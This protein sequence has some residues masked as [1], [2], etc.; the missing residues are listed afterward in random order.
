[1]NCPN[2]LSLLLAFAVVACKT[3]EPTP[4]HAAGK[5]APQV[6]HQDEIE[7]H[8]KEML[9]RGRDVFR[10]DTFASEEFWGGKLQLHKAILGEKQ[11]GVGPGVSPKM[12]LSVGLKVDAERV[13]KAVAEGIKNGTVSLDDPANTAALLKA[14]AVVGVKAFFEGPKAPSMGITCAL[15]H[16]TVD[17]SFAKGI[18]RRLDGW[19]NRDLNIGVIVSPAPNLTPMADLLG[20]DEATVRKCWGPASST[21]S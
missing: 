2:C 13:P 1:M 17:D 4:E 20:V 9:A 16:S 21:P 12:A 10:D 11:G 18:G 8:A 7:A 3:P 14:N 15:C 6:S 19:P 5:N